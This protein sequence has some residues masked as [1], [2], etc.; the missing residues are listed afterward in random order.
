[1]IIVIYKKFNLKNIDMVKIKINF[2]I[3][4]ENY[5]IFYVL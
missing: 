5:L 1:M 3:G 2:N 4:F